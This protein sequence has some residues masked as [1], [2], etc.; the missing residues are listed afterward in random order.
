MEKKKKTK[1]KYPKTN[2]KKATNKYKRKRNYNTLLEETKNIKGKIVSPILSKNLKTLK[3]DNRNNLKE[4]LI[5]E[6]QIKIKNEYAFDIELFKNNS[7]IIHNSIDYQRL[8]SQLLNNQNFMI[9]NK[10]LYKKIK[11]HENLNINE[12]LEFPIGM[13]GNCFYRSVSFFLFRD[14]NYFKLI[15]ETL[16]EFIKKKENILLG[17]HEYIDYFGKLYPLKDYINLIKNNSFYAGDLEIAQSVYCFKFNIAVYSF[18]NKD[19]TYK[20][21][22]FYTLNNSED[23]I[24]PILILNFNNTINHYQVLN[25][26]YSNT[27]EPNIN[28]NNINQINNFNTPNKDNIYNSN[29]MNYNKFSTLSI[30]NINELTKMITNITLKKIKL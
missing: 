23:N 18:D 15:R 22:L 27:I 12:V 16:Y 7:Y 10:Y 11:N 29:N 17:E 20:F 24:N 14:E 3:V 26:N 6:E 8:F 19:N 1:I 4:S 30:N 5:K 21:Q 9:K 25:Y 28:N 2:N 13:D